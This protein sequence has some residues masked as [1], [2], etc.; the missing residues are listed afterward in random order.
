MNSSTRDQIFAAKEKLQ[1]LTER[2]REEESKK[3]TQ[4]ER[5]ESQAQDRAQEEARAAHQQNK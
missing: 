5:D 2:A 1:Q 4:D 3:Q